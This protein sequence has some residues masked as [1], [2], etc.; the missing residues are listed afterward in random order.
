MSRLGVWGGVAQT[1]EKVTDASILKDGDVVTFVNE[2]NKVALGAANTNNFGQ[3]TITLK[4]N[5]FESV[6]GLT[7]LTL[8][9]SGNNWAFKTSDNQYLYA[10]SKSANQMKTWDTNDDGN[11]QAEITISSGNATVKFTGTNTHNLIRYNSGSKIFSCYASGQ[12]AIQ[13][14]K[15]APSG[16][17]THVTFGTDVDGKT[18]D[19]NEGEETSFAAKTASEKDNV[20]G[21]IAYASNKTNIVSVDAATGALTYG[22]EY[23]EATITATFTPTDATTYQS[24]TASY[25][26][27]YIEKQKTATTLTFNEGEHSLKLGSTMTVKA[28]LTANDT[29]ISGDVKY[30]SSATNVATVDETTGVVTPLKEGETTITATYEGSLEYKPATAT[31][32]I[33]VVD[34][35][36]K[37][38]DAVVFY[39]SFNNAGGTGGNDDKWSDNIA[40]NNWSESDFDQKGWTIASN[41]YGADQCIRIGSSKNSGAVTTPA[42][43][44]DGDAVLTFNAGAWAKDASKLTLTISGGGTFEG[45]KDVTI[46]P[47]DSEFSTY[48]VNIT[49]GTATTKI[50]FTSSKRVF[51]DEVKVT[52]KKLVPAVTLDENAEA[53]ATDEVLINHDDEL[54]YLTINRTVSDT[55]LNPVCFPFD[56]TKEQ[57][58]DV[59]GEGA[60]VNEYT[61]VTGTVMNF[62][63][64][65]TMTA[66]KPYI[67]KAT[68]GF[69]TKDIPG[70]TLKLAANKENE[71]SQGNDDFV[72][73]FV[74]NVE[75]FSFKSTEGDQL[76]LGKDGNLYRP[77]TVGQNLKGMRAYFDEVLDVT[78]D[79]NSAKVNIGGTLTSISQIMKGEAMTG[80]VYNLNGQYVGTSLT[81]LPKG[82]YIMNGKKY[83]VK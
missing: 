43:G 68:Q 31:Y 44:I 42:L 76:F 26:I 83:V 14:Y 11:S 58:A 15:K 17:A 47:K 10:A 78:G 2:A 82:L 62:T 67:V 16:T 30:T 8:E 35:N 56:L 45:E 9:K 28:V 71:V 1:W 74:G 46:S 34:P 13:L 69:T 38:V 41:V 7:E 27:N 49:G 25:T 54:V 37:E 39:E 51:L 60:V 12:L 18:F 50:K 20:A 22:K 4:N 40:V 3:V 59:F 24:S 75:K 63:P 48:T 66:N 73:T 52:Q 5:T 21:T 53:D 19:V 81:S 70:V 79:T 80:K 61:S 65:T 57:I 64:T 77:Q 29:E 33:E 6:T 72:A 23:G 55:Y 36:K 32:V